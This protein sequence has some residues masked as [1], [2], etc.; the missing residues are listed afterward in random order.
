MNTTDVMVNNGFMDNVFQKVEKGKCRIALNGQ[1]AIQTSHGYKTFSTKTGTLTNC[2]NFV[3][4]F[5]DDFFYV[6]PSARV[7]AGDIILV[8]GS[9]RCVISKE[10]KMIT[11]M[12]YETGTI[13]NI[14]PER[15]IFMGNIYFYHKIISPMLGM[16]AGGKGKT[17]RMFRLMMMSDMMKGAGGMGAANGNMNMMQLLMMQG[18]MKDVGG[19]VESIF[20]EFD[21]M[22]IFEEKEEEDE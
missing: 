4:N 19:T 13:E 15:N 10:G 21:E 16:F 12:T 17:N 1:I 2:S 11:V 6:V 22:D 18:M 14:I 20:D 9:P 3:S 5:G 8:N 7:K